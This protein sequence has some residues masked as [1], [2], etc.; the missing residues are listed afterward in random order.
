MDTIAH[1]EKYG[2]GQN[3]Y[4]TSKDWRAIINYIILIICYLL[5]IFCLWELFWGKW[6]IAVT[7]GIFYLF[8]ALGM[9]YFEIDSMRGYTTISQY[10]INKIFQFSM[11]IL[12]LIFALSMI[13]GVFKDS[14]F[15]IILYVGLNVFIN[16][17]I[18]LNGFLHGTFK[19]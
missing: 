16:I 10:Q 8:I 2:M 7:K 15:F 1:K 6:N 12:F 5:Y 19:K 18:L 11:I 17:A 4:Q 9:A 3:A 13:G 14:I